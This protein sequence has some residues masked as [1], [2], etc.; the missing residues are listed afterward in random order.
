MLKTG[1]MWNS[2]AVVLASVLSGALPA[3]AEKL[4]DQL[5]IATTGGLMGNTL[6][7]YFYDPFQKAKN[8]EI[9][10]V[11][12]EVPDQWARAKAMQRTGKVEFDIVTATGPDLVGRTDM[13]EK[14]DCAKL[15]NVQKFGVSDACQPYGVARTTGG[16]LITYNTETFKNKAPKT[17]A[18]FW[19]VKQFPGPR[20]LPDTGDSDWWVPV[21]ALLADG[22]KPEQ[23]F[24]LD[25]NRAY[26]KLD[27]IR[28]NVAVWWKTGDQV[29]QIMRSREV[30]MAMSYSG[31]ALAVVKEGVPVSMSWDQAI[32]DTGY[33]AVLKGAPDLKAAMAYLDFFYASSDAHVPFM[34][35]VNYATAS[36]SAIELLKP[37]ERKLYATSPENYE[38]LVKPD[39]AW[40][41][42]HRNDLRERWMAWLTR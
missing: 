11:A 15:P 1:W 38:K 14:I 9:V 33:M 8:V 28:P 7:K 19:D 23:L 31:R 6:A 3:A 20:G 39:F 25:I 4:E 24:P 34:R 30:I 16:M 35:A 13:L 41:G 27:E 18:D 40:I 26:K 22:V 36:K 5:V 10:P 32:R 42:E 29:Q 37:E 12:I 21:A 17:W 2:A